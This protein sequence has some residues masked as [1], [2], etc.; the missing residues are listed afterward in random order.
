MDISQSELKRIMGVLGKGGPSPFGKRKDKIRGGGPT[1]VVTFAGEEGRWIGRVDT[2]MFSSRGDTDFGVYIGVSPYRMI[3]YRAS[4]V[5]SDLCRSYWFEVDM[6]DR[7]WQKGTV[8]K[9]E[10]N[11]IGVARPRFKKGMVS[12]EII[13]AGRLTR[14]NGKEETIFE[15]ELSGLEWLSPQTRKFEGRKGQNL[16]EQ[17]VEGYDNRIPVSANELRLMENDARRAVM[18]TPGQV[19]EGGALPA[20]A[21]E[22]RAPV[23][24]GTAPATEEKTEVCPQCGNRLQAG[25]QFC[26][27][28]GHRLGGETAEAETPKVEAVAQETTVEKCPRCGHPFKPGI[29]FCGKCGHRLEA[30]TLGTEK[31]SDQ[32]AEKIVEE[33]RTAQGEATRQA[34]LDKCPDCGKP[35]E[36]GWQACPYCGA[37]LTSV[38]PECG[39]ATEPEWVACPYCSVSLEDG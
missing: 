7:T 6:G 1:A 22:V 15:H 13:I 26:G 21:A 9:R 20:E 28:C 39:K 38:C 37:R 27:K 31:P 10:H 18:R 32:S 3:F 14:T 4:S 29:Q 35:S 25:I 8:R 34:A 2:E 36:E 11:G 5:F 33:E 16:Y 30:E 23:R 17:L 24:V 19:A 12:R